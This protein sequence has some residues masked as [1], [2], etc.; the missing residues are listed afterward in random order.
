MEINIDMDNKM[1]IDDLHLQKMIFIYNAL[2]KGW[3]IKKKNNN[4]YIFTKN[5]EGEKDIF[6]DNYLRRFM[7]DNFDIEK[8]LLKQ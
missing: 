1:K 5:H 3:S 7:E 2:D 4:H 8:I 6:L